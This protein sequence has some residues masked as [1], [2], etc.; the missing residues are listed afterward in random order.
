[1]TLT[2]ILAHVGAVLLKIVLLLTGRHHLKKR[3]HT[4]KSIETKGLTIHWARWYDPVVSLFT[5]G[6]A[7]KLRRMTVELAQL[8]KGQTVLDIGCGTGDLTQLVHDEVGIEGCVVG[9]DASAEMIET[10]QKKYPS[11]DFRLAAVEQLPFE[12]NHFDVIISSLVLHHLPEELKGDA[13]AEMWRVLKPH[14]R[15]VHVDFAADGHRLHGYS[16][17][18][19]AAMQ[20]ADFANITTHKTNFR[21]LTCLRGE[22]IMPAK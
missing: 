7:K 4:H 18:N 12:D 6:R 13:M 5:F 16:N 19:Q 11:V 21:M 9:V 17:A 3:Q 8:E 1:M 22:K 14:G 20:Q 10:A 15:V 2:L